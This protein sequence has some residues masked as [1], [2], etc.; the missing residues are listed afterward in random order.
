MTDAGLSRRNKEEIEK[1][2]GEMDSCPTPIQIKING[3]FITKA[4][5]GVVMCVLIYVT[6]GKRENGPS[7]KRS[8]LWC[9]ISTFQFRQVCTRDDFSCFI[10]RYPQSRPDTGRGGGVLSHFK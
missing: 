5:V 10:F 1:Y 6:K 9:S 2:C 8:G 7:K 4:R 3:H